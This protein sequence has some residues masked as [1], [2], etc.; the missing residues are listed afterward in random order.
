M[1][2][3]KFPSLVFVENKQ[4]I[5]QYVNACFCVINELNPNEFLQYFNNSLELYE[6][7]YIISF[8][9]KLGCKY[10]NLLN[11]DIVNG[12]LSK[13]IDVRSNLMS[14]TLERL[15]YYNYDKHTSFIPDFVIHTNEPNR[16]LAPDTQKLIMEAKTTPYLTK[17]G[18]YWDFFKLNVYLNK[19]KYR[20]A[21][22]FILN[23]PKDKVEMLLTSYFSKH[24]YYDKKQTHRFSFIIQESIN[25][26]PQI[27]KLQKK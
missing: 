8:S 4:E 1:K 2:S 9:Y 15:K 23:T 13:K 20:N 11:D 14:T 24:Y 12:E 22:Y 25:S 17:K 16:K 3:L 10:S 19:L 5:D 18:F 21:V 7:N 26:V 6:R 27:Y